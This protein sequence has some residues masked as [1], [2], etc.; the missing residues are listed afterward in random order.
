MDDIFF[1]DYGTDW[2]QAN[3]TN[4][5][6]RY[7]LFVRKTKLIT[8]L[9]DLF[10]ITASKSTT[11]NFWIIDG[12]IRI[13]PGVKLE[14]NI[15]EWDNKYIHTWKVFSD[16]S[17][18]AHSIYFLSKNYSTDLIYKNYNSLIGYE[19]THFDIFFISYN[20]PTAEENYKKLLTRFPRAKHI[21][22]I[23]GI[24][25]AHREAAKAS[26]T[27]MFW[28]VDAD[29]NIVP[30]FN[31]NFKPR[32]WDY[33]KVYVWRS[34]NPV[35]N[36][37]YGYGG[38]KL[39]P[40]QLVIDMDLNSVDMTTSISKKFKVMPAV[41]NITAFNTDPF[42]TWR[43]AFRECCKL[44]SKSIAGQI[45]DETTNRL[46]AWCMLNE[47]T[48]YGFYAYSGALAGKA[49]GQKNAS[50]QE[51]LSKINDFNWL[52]DQWS[53]EKSQL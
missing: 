47:T 4:I 12:K 1:I 35:N 28:V 6:E 11:D 37:E 20:E 46:N 38:V 45:D 5:S 50:D 52:Q 36:L 22:G 8:N 15:P 16:Y 43:S 41:S 31:F 7:P 44:S 39:F 10:K 24:H 19:Y 14:S 30:E 26:T 27:D 32:H 3:Y 17:L 51:A 2:S 23:K 49:Y 48:P 18:N 42:S 29:A 34:R 25:N 33:D 13:Y 9:D 53:L 21:S 40:R